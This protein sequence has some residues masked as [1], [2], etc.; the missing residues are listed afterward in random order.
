MKIGDK[1]LSLN[2]LRAFEATGRHLNMSRAAEELNITQSAVSHQIRQLE[3]TLEIELFI[4]AAR[5]LRL[6]PAG[7]KLLATVQRS[8][9]E[10]ATT[11]LAVSEDLVHGDLRI[12]SV[13]GFTFLWLAKRLPEFLERFPPGGYPAA[14]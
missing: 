11:I 9:Q 8:F 2:A 3:S 12:A 6:T 1:W 13:P 14:S 5:S 4:R 10:I 7:T